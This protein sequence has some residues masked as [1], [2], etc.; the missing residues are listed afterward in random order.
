VSQP[1]TSLHTGLGPQERSV[2]KLRAFAIWLAAVSTVGLLLFTYRH[3]EAVADGYSQTFLKPLICEVTAALGAG[4]LFL[5]VWRLARRFPLGG[6]HGL[7]RL[8]LYLGAMLAFSATHT[9]LNWGLREAAFR[10]A[11]LGDYDYGILPIRYAMELPAD[12]LVFWIMVGALHGAARLK[13]A[14]EREVKAAQLERSLAQAQLRNLRLQLQPHFLFNALN[15]ISA[16]MYEDPAAADEMLDRLAELLRISLKT[17]QT[18]EVPLGAEMEA[19]DC[20]LALMRAR[21][22]DRLEVS[23]AIDS[24]A[25]GAL[26]PSLLL[27]PLVENAVRHGGAERTGRGRIAVRAVRAGGELALEVTD[28]GPGLDAGRRPPAGLDARRALPEGGLGLSATAERLQLL[29]GSEHRLEAGAAP[30]GG[31]RVGIRLPYRT[32]R[33]E[34]A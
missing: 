22:G 4:L 18:D 5:P 29:Y 26:V 1:A 24:E 19:L 12:V 15:T 16:T 31:F 6:G 32:A 13:A 28:D 27:Q 2:A 30:G 14:R 8:P 9:S 23:L 10:A 7:A 33:I 20:Y 34:A 11:G 25:R 17:A 3:L 21:F